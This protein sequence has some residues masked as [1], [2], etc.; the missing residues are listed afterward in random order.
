MSPNYKF[1]PNQ[2]VC[3]QEVEDELNE[4]KE[5]ADIGLKWDTSD[6]YKELKKNCDHRRKYSQMAGSEKRYEDTKHNYDRTWRQVANLS[7][8]VVVLSLGI[9]YQF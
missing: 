6:D 3:T 7:L 5:N 8:G 2:F 9:M 4:W 1:T